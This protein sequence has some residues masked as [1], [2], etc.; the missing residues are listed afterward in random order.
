VEDK[1]IIEALVKAIKNNDIALDDVPQVYK[2]QVEALIK[3][4]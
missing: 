3:E 2:A 4:A 1:L